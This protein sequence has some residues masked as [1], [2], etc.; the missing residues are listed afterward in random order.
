MRLLGSIVSVCVSLDIL[1][2]EGFEKKKC[3][4]REFC[5][6]SDDDYEQLRDRCSQ[7]VHSR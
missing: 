3:G 5:D 6:S 1:V 4:D 2:E 7:R